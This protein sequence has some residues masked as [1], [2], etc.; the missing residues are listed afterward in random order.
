MPVCSKNKDR[1]TNIEFKKMQRQTWHKNRSPW[2]KAFY[3]IG[4][5]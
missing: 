5:T 2:Q 4:V 1:A 3:L